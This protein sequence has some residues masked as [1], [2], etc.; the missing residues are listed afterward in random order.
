MRPGS[1]LFE[2]VADWTVAGQPQQ[3]SGTPKR[4]GRARYCREKDAI[5]TL[6]S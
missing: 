4:L 3:V 6:K 1:L 2:F 5:E